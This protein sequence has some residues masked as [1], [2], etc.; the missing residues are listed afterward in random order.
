M[1]YELITQKEANRIVHILKTARLYKDIETEVGEFV[2]KVFN[3]SKNSDSEH[4]YDMKEFYLLDAEDELGV[5]NYKNKKYDI[6]VN[7]GD[8]G[9]KTRLNNVHISLGS[10]KFHEYCFQ[11][12]LSQAV[13]DEENIYIIKNISNMGGLGAICRLYRGLKIDNE[14]Y[15]L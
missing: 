13:K 7:V 1:L 4:Y 3:I 6:Y 10:S 2:L 9:Y 8:W 14:L 12:E 15:V 11:I 5:L